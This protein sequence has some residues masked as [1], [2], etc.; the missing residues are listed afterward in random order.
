MSLWT[1]DSLKERCKAHG[2][3]YS[4][5]NKR[6][7]ADLAYT[8]KELHQLCREHG[9]V[10]YSTK[11]KDELLDMLTGKSCPIVMKENNKKAAN[12]PMKESSKKAAKGATSKSSTVKIVERTVMVPVVRQEMYVKEVDTEKLK[13]AKELQKEAKRLEKEGKAGKWKKV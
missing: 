13:L 1:V 12:V 11:S 5:K 10:G 3:P 9:I 6:E 2:I 7:L 4:G 8:L